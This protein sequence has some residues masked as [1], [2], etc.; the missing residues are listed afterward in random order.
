MG[1][2]LKRESGSTQP[3]STKGL[4]EEQD[5]E[6]RGRQ[7]EEKRGRQHKLNN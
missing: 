4:Q 5:E 6:G 7:H 2:I 1:L 3:G